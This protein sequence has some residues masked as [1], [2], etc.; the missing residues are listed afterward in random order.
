[1]EITLDY[2][3]PRPIAGRDHSRSE[4]WKQ[5]CTLS[6]RSWVHIAAPSGSGKTTLTHLLFGLRHDYTGTLW[7]HGRD[8]GTWDT[9][10]WSHWRSRQASV[11]FQ[12]L[13]LLENYTAEDNIRLNAEIVGGVS[14]ETWRSHAETLGVAG[15]LQQPVRELSQG[16]R[17]RVA[18]IRA[19]VQPFQWLIM[20][21]PF[22]HLDADTRSKSIHLIQQEV[23][24]KEAG[25]I[26][27]Q[28]A[29]DDYFTYTK[30]FRL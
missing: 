11:V 15:Q 3:L 23:E 8:A 21:E 24:S 20:D 5:R 12:D 18:I 9:G 4:I 22:S 1:M 30:K 17:Q 10:A 13:R 2:L 29:E 25:M 19:L 16:E 14:P 26:I 7:L 6:P 27:M 28:L